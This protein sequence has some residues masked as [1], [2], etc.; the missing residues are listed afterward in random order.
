MS[1]SE[2]QIAAEKARDEKWVNV[3]FRVTAAEYRILKRLAGKRPV[4]GWARTQIRKAA[5]IPEEA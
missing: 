5:G 4:P 2:A 1:R 3:Q